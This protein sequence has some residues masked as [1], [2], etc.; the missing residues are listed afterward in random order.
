MLNGWNEDKKVIIFLPKTDEDLTDFPILINLTSQIKSSNGV[1][2]V[3]GLAF[4]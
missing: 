1:D 4:I 3:R 2:C